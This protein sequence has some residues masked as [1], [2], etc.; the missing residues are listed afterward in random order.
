MLYLGIDPG[1]KN[2]GIAVVEKTEKGLALVKSATFNPSLKGITGTVEQI[3]DYAIPSSLSMLNIERYVSYQ[4]VN[5]AKA[6]DILMLIGAIGYAYE[7]SRVVVEYR[8][9]I[10][11]KTWLVRQLYKKKGFNNPSLKL[12]K[13][14]SI[15]AAKSCLDVAASFRSD[16]EADAIC[17]ASLP[18]FKE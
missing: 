3:L 1:W 16:H 4:D 5:T 13:I 17:L 6:E 10:D 2:L 8:R 11:W 7:Q 14:F 9:A 18:T 12:D 15:A